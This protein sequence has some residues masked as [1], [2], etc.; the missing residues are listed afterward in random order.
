MRRYI[1]SR[2]GFSLF[3]VL[4]VVTIVFFLGRLSGDPVLLFLPE[5]AT[6]Q[7]V[8][9]FR[10][11]LGLDRPL[12]LQ[13]LSYLERVFLHLDFGTSIRHRRPAAVLVLER[14]PATLEL[15]ASALLISLMIALPL[16][17]LSAVY[18]NSVLDAGARFLALVGQSTPLFWLEVIMILVFAVHLRILPAFG[19]GGLI[20][21]VL[22]S[23]ALGTYSAGLVMRILRAEIITILGQD[24]VR[25]ARAKGLQNR[26]VYIRHVLKN[27][28]IPVVTLVGIQFG[29]M[30]SGVF[31]TEFVFAY[32]GMGRLALSAIFAR[33]FPVVEA[34]AVFSAVIMASVN[35]VVDMLYVWLDPRIRYE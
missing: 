26:S 25:T 6:P 32:P 10:R 5:Q 15:A 34:F 19:R 29:F 22:P 28:G 24:F 11:E 30:L 21:L 20:H 35:I 27:A 8:E 9:A 23:V 14:V 33:D 3:V 7:Q 17:V 4:G 16:G 18:R 13:Y 1:A 12:G 31:I 2:L